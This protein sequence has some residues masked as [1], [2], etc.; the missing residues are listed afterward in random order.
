MVRARL[1]LAVELAF[2]RIDM[3]AE[4]LMA[5]IGHMRLRLRTLATSGICF[6]HFSIGGCPS[7]PEFRS[8][9]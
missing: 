5:L 9:K 2:I 3:S 7:M 4:T 8:I 1:S 6:G